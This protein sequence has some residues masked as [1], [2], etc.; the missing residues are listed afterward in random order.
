[1]KTKITFLIAFV[2][3]GSYFLQDLI[4]EAYN[5]QGEQKELI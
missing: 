4:F 5:A 2:F 3:L 1:M